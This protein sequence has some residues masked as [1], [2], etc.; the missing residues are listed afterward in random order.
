MPF[1]DQLSQ[2]FDGSIATGKYAVQAGSASNSIQCGQVYIIN[3]TTPITTPLRSPAALTL[4][5]GPDMHTSLNDAIENH[6]DSVQVVSIPKKRKVQREISIGLGLRE[7]ADSQITSAKIAT[8]NQSQ[9]AIENLAGF[10][11]QLSTK[12]RIFVSKYFMK[13][14]DEAAMYN[15][16]DTQMKE[17]TIEEILMSFI[18]Q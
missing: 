3:E 7:L 17:G 15:Y 14:V 4:F 5:S 16:M 6:N 8:T 9:L 13:N 11:P 2:I 12:E 10:A 1:Y 18:S